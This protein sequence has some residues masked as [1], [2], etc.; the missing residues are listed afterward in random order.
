MP[1]GWFVVNYVQPFE[2]H[3]EEGFLHELLMAE[4]K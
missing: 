4:E 2:F 3:R 1:C